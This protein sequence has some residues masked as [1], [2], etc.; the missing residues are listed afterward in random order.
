MRIP[1]PDRREQSRTN[2]LTKMSDFSPP[3]VRTS[4]LSS[5]ASRSNPPIS[6]EFR[7]TPRFLFREWRWLSSKPFGSAE[8]PPGSAVIRIQ[9][10]DIGGG[11]AELSREGVQVHAMHPIFRNETRASCIELWY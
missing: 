5:V 7:V 1:K 6:F 9:G 10:S 11:S 2:T 8:F 4:V 3:Y